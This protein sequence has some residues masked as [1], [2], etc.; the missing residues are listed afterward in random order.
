MSD[1]LAVFVTDITPE[2]I[3]L[4]PGY[5]I[6]RK[7]PIETLSDSFVIETAPVERLFNHLNIVNLV[8]L[9]AVNQFVLCLPQLPKT[10]RYC[11]SLGSSIRLKNR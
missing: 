5:L 4:K 9:H 8:V 6:V 10:N 1:Q 3:T 7:E 11:S 2:L